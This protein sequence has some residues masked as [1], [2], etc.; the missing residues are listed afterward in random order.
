MLSRNE[1]ILWKN[2]TRKKSETE[3]LK[4]HFAFGEFYILSRNS[5]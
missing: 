1:E 5:M 4:I 3:Y 2:H